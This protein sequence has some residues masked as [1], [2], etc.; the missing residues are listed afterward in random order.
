MNEIRFPRSYKVYL[1]FLA[2]AAILVFMLP[3]SAKFK[4]DYKKGSPWM[5]ENLVSQFDFPILKTSEELQRE[6]EELASKTIQYFRKSPEPALSAKTTLST[7]DLHELNS[8]RGDIIRQVEQIYS[9]GVIS[10]ADLS[11]GGEML[12]IQKD[13]R[14]SEVPSSEVY[15]LERAKSEILAML[16]SALPEQNV[17]SLCLDR[18]I[19][20]L[21]IPDLQFD[22]KTTELLHFN[23]AEH[24]STTNGVVTAGEL[25]VS[26]GETVTA[27]IE[28][29]LDSYKAE[30]ERTV[31]YQGPSALLWLG[32]SLLALLLVIL[33][34]F[35]IFY[36]NYRIFREPNRYLYLLLL[37]LIGS[38]AAMLMDR[39]APNFIYMTPFTL[40]AIYMLAFFKTRVVLPVYIVTLL[41]LLFVS[42][43]G[44]ELFVMFLAAG[45]LTIYTFPYFSR[46]WKQFLNS[47]CCFFT[48]ALVWTI[49]RLIGG[50][51]FAGEYSALFQLFLGS[52]LCVAGYPLIYLF[53]TIFS[54]VSTNRLQ[55]LCDTNSNK[56]LLALSAK[57]PG[58]F[59]HSLQ[60]MNMSEAAASAV[61]ANVPLIRAGAMYHD[62]G[63]M[64]NP[65]CFVENTDG[66]HSYHDGL[67]P[68]ESARAILRHVPDGVEIARKY[69]LP[70]IIQDFILTHHGTTTAG[71]FYA[72]FL[73]QG[74]V[75]GSP[76]A[77]EFTYKGR[78]PKTK[79]Q[80]IL[81]LCDSCEAAVRSLKE[82][83]PESIAALVD[84]IIYRKISDG[85]LNDSE[86]SM[87]ELYTVRDVIRDYSQQLNHPRIAY[88]SDEKPAPQPSTKARWRSRRRV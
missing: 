36:T 57:A 24:L 17:D 67:T 65:L 30:Y 35:V 74:G 22:S 12:L 11:N 56:L 84:K 15:S 79:E 14:A 20:N 63:K 68:V 88:P 69:R 51:T 66:V 32:N 49:F 62:I 41:P 83:T 75:P 16:S 77:A 43:N 44:I 50:G 46:G 42:H 18:G 27:E 28:Q 3:H 48:L 76:Q 38:A 23:S 40:V 55:E 45:V 70:S 21:I 85:Q 9:K 73:K 59:Q 54:L 87:S 1:C 25:I 81:M 31:G 33:L 61:G 5:Y 13:K 72:E 71:F 39:Y 82:K 86:I 26:K 60:V 2:A 52:L 37:F 58:T 53:E 34:F 8:V 7:A 78:K 29:M 64:A 6:K 4:Y 10:Q 47:L 80:V 19:Y